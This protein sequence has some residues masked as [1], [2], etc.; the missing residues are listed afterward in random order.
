MIYE[1]LIENIS[2]LEAP[3]SEEWWPKVTL[4]V[5]EYSESD[6]FDEDRLKALLQFLM[7]IP[8]STNLRRQYD[9]KPMSREAAS[10]RKYALNIVSYGDDKDKWYSTYKRIKQRHGIEFQKQVANYAKILW[11]TGEGI[12]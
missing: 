5:D 1:E 3:F 4:C 11:K 12:K 9:S 10:I 8:Q 7:F 2:K 6:C